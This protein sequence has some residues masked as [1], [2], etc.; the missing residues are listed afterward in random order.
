MIITTR[1]IFLHVLW[2]VVI[3]AG[4]YEV[5]HITTKMDTDCAIIDPCSQW[6]SLVVADKR[7]FPNAGKK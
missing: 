1:Q 2:A 4:L 3:L 6:D 5:H 7:K